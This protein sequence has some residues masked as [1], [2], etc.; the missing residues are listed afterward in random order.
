MSDQFPADGNVIQFR[1]RP[2]CDPLRSLRPILTAIENHPDKYCSPVAIAT[3]V[4]M[5]LME[6]APDMEAAIDEAAVVLHIDFDLR[7]TRN[8]EEVD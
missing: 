1:R 7:L 3:S 8:T 5:V 4:L 2:P 6:A